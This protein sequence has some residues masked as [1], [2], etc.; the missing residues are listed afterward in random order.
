[1]SKVHWVAL[2][3]TGRVGGK[4]I[5][6]LLRHF[7]S[8]GAVLDASMEELLAVPHI[9]RATAA[10]IRKIDMQRIEA[11]CS[12]LAHEG[13]NILTWEDTKLYPNNLLL[14]CDESPPVLFSRGMPHLTDSRAVAV[15]GTR[16]PRHDSAALT[17]KIAYELARRGWI[18]VSGLALGI[19]SAAH[20]GALEAGGRTLAVLGSGLRRVYPPAHDDLAGE[21]AQCGAV[22]SELHP[23]EQV[24]PQTLIA[25]NR[26]T[27]GLSRA[28]IVVQSGEDSGSMSTARRAWQ[29]G[30]TVFAVLGGD[31][32]CDQLLANGAHPL[33]PATLDYDAL[34]DQLDKVM[35]RDPDSPS[36]EMPLF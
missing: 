25:R 6:R 12:Q 15:V 26:I 16:T 4:T 17:H 28:V 24:S 19:D 22:L 33:D 2:A 27:S 8:L 32:G 31:A 14:N 29:Q 7:G 3:M 34:S 10:A 20:R 21:I 30:R 9:G 36:A 23:D 11:E 13:I 18:I 1:M 35:I 5:T